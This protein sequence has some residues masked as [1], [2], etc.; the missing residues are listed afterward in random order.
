MTYAEV[1][2]KDIWH[3]KHEKN[4]VYIYSKKVPHSSIKELKITST[5]N[6]HS[7]SCIVAL[8]NDTDSYPDWVYSCISST[9]LKQ[10]SD[11]EIIYHTASDF[12]WPMSD[13][14]FVVH[15]KIWQNDETGA[16]H[17]KSKAH[18]NYIEEKEGVVRVT[19]FTAEWIITPIEEGKFKL[20]YTFTADPEGQIPTWI[21]N[22]F[23]EFGPLKTIEQI[24]IHAA[25]KKYKNARFDYIAE[26]FPEN[27]CDE[28]NPR[29]GS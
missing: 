20:H 15:N 26:K 8:F 14:D 9:V 3:L 17:S 16:F 28:K 25:K 7:L 21:V 10:I 29:K 12:P 27:I 6:G 19:H 1:P 2:D 18:N 13:R 23:A 11:T 5:I 4:D 22:T 24:E